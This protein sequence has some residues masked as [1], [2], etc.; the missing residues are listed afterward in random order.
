MHTPSSPFAD[1]GLQTS[2]Q[3][4]VQAREWAQDSVLALVP[5]V[6]VE[7]DWTPSRILYLRKHSR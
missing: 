5:E 1:E 3:G 7:R 4:S 2:C 6:E